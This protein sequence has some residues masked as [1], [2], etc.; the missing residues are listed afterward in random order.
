[1]KQY[2][3]Y[4]TPGFLTQH[5]L[6]LT[7]LDELVA[8]AIERELGKACGIESVSV[9]V[10]K[11]KLTVRYDASQVSIDD[12]ISALSNYGVAQVDSWWGRLKLGWQRQ[13]DSNV[14]DSAKHEAHCCNKAPRR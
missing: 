14:A 3:K 13:I 9:R 2:S 11:S 8:Q 5:S 7:G 6:R 4:I 10:Q 12:V 1:M